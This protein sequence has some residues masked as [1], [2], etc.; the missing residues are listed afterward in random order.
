[1][2]DIVLGDSERVELAQKTSHQNLFH[3]A[4]SVDD[5]VDEHKL[6]FYAINDAPW[7]KDY[8]APAS[9]IEVE[10]LR[11]DSTSRRARPERGRFATNLLQDLFGLLP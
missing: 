11:Y 9:Q 8:L 5:R 10:E 6:T 1:M 2:V 7:G 3:V 4:A